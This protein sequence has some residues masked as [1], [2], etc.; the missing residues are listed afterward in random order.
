MKFNWKDTLLRLT[1]SETGCPACGADCLVVRERTEHDLLPDLRGIPFCACPRCHASGELAPLVAATS[2]KTLEETVRD[3]RERGELEATGRD[4]EAYIARKADQDAVDV[5]FAR[6]VSRMRE[7][8]HLGGI[9]AGL[10]V[11]N[12]R[13]LPPDTGLFVPTDAPRHFALLQNQRY[14]RVPMTLYR[15]RFD[16]ETTCI[17]AQNPKT[18]QREHRLRVTGDVGVYL[19]DYRPGEVPT[20]LVGTHNPRIAAQVYGAVRAETSLPSPVVGIA[21]FPLPNRFSAVRTLY[22]IDA[23]DAPLPLAFAVRAMSVPTVYGSDAKPFIRVLQPHGPSSDITAADI[24]VLS[25]SRPHGKP[26]EAWVAER[27]LGLADSREEVANALL[28][29]GATEGTRALLVDLL[30]D[31]PP[32]TLVETILLPTTEPDDVFALGNGRLVKSTPVGI[33]TAV[34]DRKTDTVS[35]RGLLCNVGISVDLRIAD[36]GKETACCTVT[37]P[38]P[39]VPS[40]PV[41]LPRAHW[42]N[43]D[44]IAEDVRE[45]YAAC[46]RTPYVAF[47]RAQGYSWGDI[48]QYLGSHCPVQTGLKA[49]G[50]TA[51]GA[52][53]LPNAVLVRGTA[54]AQTKAGLLSP[55][56]L[57]AYGALAAE[58][59]DDGPDRLNYFLTSEASLDRTGVAA[60][61]LHTLYCAAGVQF[62]RSGVRRPPSHLV[63]VETEPGV[64]DPTLRTLAYLF[65]GSEYVPPMDYADR[66]GF[67]YRWAGLGTLPLVTRLPSADDIATVLSSSPVSVIAV[68]DPLTAV[69]LSGRGTVSFVLPHV[70]A[71]EAGIMSNDIEGLRTAFVSLAARKCGTGWMDIGGG[72]SSSAATPSLSVLASLTDE[73]RPETVAGGLYRSVKGRYHG[74]GLTGS[75]AFL[76]VL[77]RAYVAST[78]GDDTGIQLTLVAGAPADALKASFNERGEHVFICPDHVIVSRSVVQLINREKTYLFDAEQ[79]SREFTENGIIEPDAPKSLGLDGRRVWVFPRCV[80]DDEVVR[81]LGF[82]NRKERRK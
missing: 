35:T 79:L 62:D 67:L 74:A 25:D 5:H 31:H 1:G 57:Y 68:A 65:S 39:D 80:W 59:Q 46:G 44:L 12:L 76:G 10:S 55:E 36:R 38:D 20:V 69:S 34:R 56:V 60:G 63:F 24:R 16:A 71:T 3:L 41:R 32:A 49:L 17:D 13:Q 73:R 64:W 33:Y 26:L 7:A 58:I 22:L 2:G 81:G 51:E 50:L 42:N 82:T 21:G 61:L 9:R 72:G 77:H 78:H 45:A 27:I 75:R 37:H 30:G 18:L 48:L 66:L 11:A 28:Q 14:N 19:G 53:N 47:Y 52:V 29:A 43:P 8:P 6:C 40:V 23:P 70:E 15:Y 4:A 54:R